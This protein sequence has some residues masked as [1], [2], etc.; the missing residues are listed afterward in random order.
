MRYF[1]VILVAS[2]LACGVGCRKPDG[3][4]ST[5]QPSKTDVLV[6]CHF[7]GT[8][9]LIH[10]TNAARARELWTLPESRRLVDQTLQKLAHA[11]RTLCGDRVTAAQDERGAALLRPMLDDVLRG[12]SFLQVRG[13]ADR[14]AEWT[15]LVQ[16]PA[17]RLKVWRAGLTEP[18]WNSRS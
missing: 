2:A 17:D 15:L 3:A 5:G 4:E 14:T 13:P 8:A 16:L 11:P 12:E 6:R 7:V 10:N 1:I 9:S 18:Y